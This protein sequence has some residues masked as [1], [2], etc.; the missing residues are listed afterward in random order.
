MLMSYDFSKK[1]IGCKHGVML[2]P[3]IKQLE[4]I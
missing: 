3:K 4:I 1:R 2:K